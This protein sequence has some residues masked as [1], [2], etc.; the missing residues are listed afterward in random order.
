MPGTRRAI[1]LAEAVVFHVWCSYFRWTGTFDLSTNYCSL[2]Y[3]DVTASAV[4]AFACVSY[5]EANLAT[6]L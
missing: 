5:I 2:E 6:L 4:S 3:L 1:F